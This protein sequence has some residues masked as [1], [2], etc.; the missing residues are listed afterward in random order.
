MKNTEEKSNVLPSI[1]RSFIARCD[2]YQTQP[3]RVKRPKWTDVYRGYPKNKS[4]TDDLPAREVFLSIF[5]EE[6]YKKNTKTFSN[7]C[8]TRVSL[9]LIE[10]GMK[11]KAAF[12]IIKKGHKHNNKGFQTSAL[13]LKNFLIERNVWGSPEELIKAKYKGSYNENVPDIRFSDVQN[14]IGKRN[15][16]YIIIPKKGY[17]N[18]SA[19]SGHATLWVGANRD[20]I[21]GHNYA[22]GAL[23]IYF[24][25]LK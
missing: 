4:G 2:D 16:V 23:E 15:G 13:G 21:G 11:V 22:E 3:I 14:T 5:E 6:Y 10:G 1:Y 9:G 8:A 20:V 19:V 12:R 18:D 24:W 17:F 25:E 7:A